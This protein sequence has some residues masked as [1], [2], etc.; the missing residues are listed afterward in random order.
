MYL[1]LTQF[2]I[3]SLLVGLPS[4]LVQLYLSTRFSRKSPLW[5][6]WEALQAELSET[7]HHPHPESQE[8][9]KLLEK[10]VIFTGS[11]LSSISDEDRKRLT[12]LLRQKVDDPK[13]EKAER[14]RAEFLLLVMPRAKDSIERRKTIN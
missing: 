13:Q 4:A 10:L 2:I 1:T 3:L 9:D 5:K 11:G 14:M 7:L 8:M 12:E 6:T